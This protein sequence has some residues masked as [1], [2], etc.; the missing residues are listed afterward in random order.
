MKTRLKELQYPRIRIKYANGNWF[1]SWKKSH[2]ETG[3]LS[4][5]CIT[6][7]K[8]C[9]SII[10]QLSLHK[11]AGVGAPCQ[12]TRKAHNWSGS[13]MKVFL[14]IY[15]NVKKVDFLCWISGSKC[16]GILTKVLFF[17][18]L[19]QTSFCFFF[20]FWYI[21]L[22]KRLC[23][24]YRIS[25]TSTSTSPEYNIMEMYLPIRNMPHVYH[26][27]TYSRFRLYWYLWTTD[28]ISKLTIFS[29]KF[30]TWFYK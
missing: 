1:R 30:H 15:V 11:I 4:P 3:S 26:F 12:C 29:V 23:A 13:N 27:I 19:R 14:F 7:E 10:T 18:L 9:L 25:Q 21:L 24:W 5:H 20:F 6:I 28:Q 22:K 17:D 8:L 16:C 2:R